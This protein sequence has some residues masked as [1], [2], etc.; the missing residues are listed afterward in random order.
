MLSAIGQAQPRLTEFFKLP[1]SLGI[2]R[3]LR[4]PPACCGFSSAEVC[5]F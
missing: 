1:L 3:S 4:G 2:A 5:V